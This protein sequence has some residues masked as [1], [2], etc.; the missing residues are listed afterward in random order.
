MIANHEHLHEQLAN[1]LEDRHVL[2]AAIAAGATAIVTENLADFP[3]ATLT[4][5]NILALSI[6]GFLSHLFAV[7]PEGLSEIISTQAADLTNPPVSVN[8]LLA[9]L[10]RWAPRF[11]QSMREYSGIP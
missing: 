7:D 1:A 2:A 6:D 5:Y 3:A 8:Q 9:H 10:A 4:Q 11:A